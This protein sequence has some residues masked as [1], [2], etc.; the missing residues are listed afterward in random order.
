MHLKHDG[1]DCHSDEHDRR[2]DKPPAH[3]DRYDCDRRD[4]R[5]DR[6]DVRSGPACERHDQPAGHVDN[7]MGHDNRNTPDRNQHAGSAAPAGN[8]GRV[9]DDN[10]HGNDPGHTD[11]SNPGRGNGNHGTQPGGNGR[12]NR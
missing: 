5:D 6:R 3:D 10:G 12:G 1:R 11:P 4:D 9:H 2:W 8:G 7:R